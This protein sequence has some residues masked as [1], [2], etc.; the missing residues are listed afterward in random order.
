MKIYY[1]FLWAW[2]K[3]ITKLIDYQIKQNRFDIDWVKF[4]IER[5]KIIDSLYIDGKCYDVTEYA[6]MTSDSFESDD[7]RFHFSSAT[8]LIYLGHIDN[9]RVWVHEFTEMALIKLLNE[10]GEQWR[11]E[12]RFGKRRQRIPHILASLTEFGVKW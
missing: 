9:C 4:V 7:T 8:A 5:Q 10:W 2:D 11:S 6:F 12:I 1:A 3:T